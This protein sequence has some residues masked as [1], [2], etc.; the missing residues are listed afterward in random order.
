[1]FVCDDR[2]RKQRNK[3]QVFAFECRHK[4]QLVSEREN[5]ENKQATVKEDRNK[6]V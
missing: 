4:Q 5:A 2:K 6:I 1:V 3:T